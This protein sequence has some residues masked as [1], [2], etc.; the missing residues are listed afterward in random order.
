MNN[1]LFYKI[2]R[3]IDWILFKI[4]FLPKVEGRENIPKD[5]SFVLI[6]NH[7]KWLDPVM[8]VAVIKRDLHFLA[9]K[10]L[11]EGPLRGLMKGMGCIPVDRKIKDK[12]SMSLAV[13]N[14]KRGNV[15]A[16]F[17][18]GTINRSD[19]L[20]LPFK[21]GAV[22]MAYKT[23]SLIV[24][25]IITGKYKLFGGIKLKILKP[26]S[27]NDD[28]LKENDRLRD[29]V[30]TELDKD[31]KKIKKDRNLAYSFVKPI[32]GT[33]YRLYY[34]P[35]IIGKGN[36]PKKGSIVIVGNHKH[37]MDQNNII[38]STKRIV[39]YMAKKEYFDGPFSW[40]FKMTGC[41]PV[42]RSIKD[43]RASGKALNVLNNGWALG[44]FPEGTRNKTKEFL[45][46]FKYGAVSMAKKTDSLIVPFGITGDY[47]FRS[48]NLTIRI[49]KPYKVTGDLISENKKLEKVIRDLMRENLKK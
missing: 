6:S 13:E 38:I 40:F 24:P 9:K 10:E 19:D 8:L 5:G 37:I 42:N 34:N 48:K 22:A 29:I 1:R 45:L 16:L 18:E 32:L 35:K 2:I 44:L 23:N 12:N 21:M 7:T 39:H 28:L 36:I 46:P 14:L 33:I 49:G 47:K 25:C 30:N 20:T 27:V 31:K 41:I 3:F 4:L 17:P 15:V 11:F 26:I 43:V